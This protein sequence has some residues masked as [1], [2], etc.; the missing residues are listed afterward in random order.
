VISLIHPSR[1]R[2]EKSFNN[3]VKW[4]N[5]MSSTE[6]VEVLISI[7]RDDPCR[8]EYWARYKVFVDVTDVLP[9]PIDWYHESSVEAINDAASCAH[10]NILIVVSDDTDCFDDWDIAIKKEVE[11][12]TDWILKTQ[13]G[14][15]PWIITMP[16]M[17]RKYFDRTGY[18]YHP[19]FDH[20]FCDTY[21]SCVADINGRRITSQLVFPHNND[22]IKDDLRKRT[23]ATWKQGEETFIKLM[24]QFT[25]E[26]RSRISDVSMKNWLRNKGVR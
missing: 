18:I 17:D 16:V 8:D 7:D 1:G 12:K 21:M 19:S 5:A 4:V 2:P 9:T 15:Q 22:S 26:E 13:D 11:G 23:D 6:N 3:M 20:M 25:P 14:I 10:N 24:K